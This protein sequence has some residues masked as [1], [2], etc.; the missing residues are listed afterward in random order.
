M[1]LNENSPSL[2]DSLD[3]G[4]HGLVLDLAAPEE[5]APSIGGN[6]TFSKRI[7]THIYTS[8]R[9]SVGS[10]VL[11][12]QRSNYEPPRTMVPLNNTLL[13]VAWQNALEFHRHVDSSNGLILL[14]DQVNTEGQLR[15]FS[16]LF[17]CRH[18]KK[19]FHPVCP[20][21]GLALTLCRDDALLAERG[22][23]GYTDSLERFLYCKTCA[24]IS[25]ASPFFVPFKGYDLP[26]I[27][28]DQ[29]ALILQYDQLLAT[30]P[31]DAALPCR[32]CPDVDACY[33]S[34]A[35]VVKRIEPVAFFPFYM[36]MFPAPTCGAE[37]FIRM[38]SGGAEAAI[39]GE[40][41][42]AGPIGE[43]RFLYQDKQRQFLEVL[44]LKLTFLSQVV[45]HL[46][47]DGR[48]EKIQEFDFSLDSI[49][50]DLIAPGAG[51]PAFWNFN[52]RILDSV[53]SFKASPFAPALPETPVLHFMAAV[54][55]QTLLVNSGQ[56]AE[57]VF[58]EIG[59]FVDKWNLDTENGALAGGLQDH[60]GMFSAKQIYWEPLEKSI[61]QQWN[62]FWEQALSLGFQLTHAGLKAGAPWDSSRF[63]ESLETLRSD[64][65]REM[66]SVSIVEPPAEDRFPKSD[67]ME[68]VLS[69]IL[70]KWQAQAMVPK[71][72]E[73]TGLAPEIPDD[74]AT[75]VFTPPD[76]DAPEP[77]I[78]T[79]QQ[80]EAQST[81]PPEPP[82]PADDWNDDI[83]ETVVLASPAAA[84]P[85]PAN[86]STPQEV[87]DTQSPW[88]DDIEE[89][90]VLKGDGPPPVPEDNASFDDADQTV[91]ISPASAPPPSPSTDPDVDLAAT[92]VQ[93]SAG[94]APSTASMPDGDMEA[95]VVIG[96]TPPPPTA[97]DDDLEATIVQ[98]GGVS[99]TPKIP[100]HDLSTETPSQQDTDPSDLET[101]VVINA[102]GRP[103]NPALPQEKIADE[104]LEATRIETPRTAGNPAELRPPMPPDPPQPPRQAEPPPSGPVSDLG[105]LDNPNEDDDIMEQTVIIRS[106]IKKE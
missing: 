85:D 78:D 45:F 86:W 99:K 41:A 94:Q 40:G 39:Q 17:F 36:M 10:V 95:T 104:D 5:S 1:D 64:V 96:A 47:A 16:P 74:E 88:E 29:Q 42:V 13:D 71:D 103:G 11:L 66:F 28:K 90:V 44:Y 25:P 22:L 32:G 82:P 58:L 33:G 80:K 48:S 68:E 63:K 14:K 46:M 49:G 87:P 59:K 52:A 101:T 65:K 31:E 53:G 43:N 60:E 54:W 21:C 38:I 27:V 91:V 7:F 3:T 92:M 9:D 73:N 62:S 98:G 6:G 81:M 102:A 55:F 83:E 89:T 30:L 37:D 2:M 24:K 35:L 77:T 8:C 19:W 61:P 56:K 50:V 34:S 105:P 67:R 70:D 4:D 26:D 51:L 69:R 18:T 106:D 72:R 97:P 75:V 57:A 84:P 23:P 93:G 79:P 76:A 15:A 12:M 100:R 20:Q